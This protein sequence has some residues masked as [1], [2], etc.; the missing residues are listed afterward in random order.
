MPPP[1]GPHPHIRPERPDDAPAIAALARDAFGGAYEADL[2]D[3]LRAES[4][5]AVSL[6]AAAEGTVV[7][8]IMFS[9]LAVELDGRA[10]PAVALAPLCVR[11]DSRRSGIGSALVRSGL[12]AARA[13]GQ[14]AAIVL[15]EPAYYRRFGFSSEL[16]RK[17]ASPFEGSAFMALELRPGA[18]QGGRGKVTYP[19]AFG[20]GD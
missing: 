9:D 8:H 3:R 18:L 19:A 1:P 14:H 6:V 12:D 4:L 5:A 15:G 2:I 20:L 13:A 16:A 11:S 10:I 7:G 17:L